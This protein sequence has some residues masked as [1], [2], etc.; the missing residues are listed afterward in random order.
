MWQKYVA[1]LQEIEKPCTGPI[2]PS[3]DLKL[4]KAESFK[5][6]RVHL[7]KYQELLYDCIS[8][9]LYNGKNPAAEASKLHQ[10]H[11]E[12]GSPITAGHKY[13]H[14]PPKDMTLKPQH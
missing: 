14:L 2:M 6:Q 11:R 1:K 7:H 12:T 5:P 3:S 13:A 10:C 4:G 8:S 9:Y